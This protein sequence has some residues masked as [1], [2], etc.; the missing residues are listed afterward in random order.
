VGIQTSR[1]SPAANNRARRIASRVSVL[2]YDI[3]AGQAR[4]AVG[5]WLAP[6]ARGRGIATRAVRLLARW[7]LDDLGLARLQITCGPDNL[8]SQRVAERAGFTREGVLRSHYPFKGSRR[9][10]VVFSLLPGDP[11]TWA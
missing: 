5:Y 9:D 1:S 10:T 8:A 4:A 11:A 7:A 2:V 6:H 3:D